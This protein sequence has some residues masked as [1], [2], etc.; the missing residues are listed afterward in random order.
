M[1]DFNANAASSKFSLWDGSGRSLGIIFFGPWT[2]AGDG[3]R[4]I[5]QVE[6]L[7][8]AMLELQK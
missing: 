2:R 5:A 3:K 8:T 7:G 4:Y 6:E 1:A